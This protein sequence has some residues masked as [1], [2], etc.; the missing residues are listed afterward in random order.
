MQ[1][2]LCGVKVENTPAFNTMKDLGRPLL[3]CSACFSHPTRNDTNMKI[4]IFANPANLGLL[5]GPVDLY[6]DT[7][8]QLCCTTNFYQCLI[9]M[10]YNHSTSSFVPILYALMTHKC[11]ELYAQVFKQIHILSD[12]KM[13][14]RTFTTDFEQGQMNMLSETF[15]QRGDFSRG[16]SL[17]LQA[18]ALQVP[19]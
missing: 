11:K 6:C 12:N 10:I 2:I 4:M 18:G 19:H 8:F 3:H 17:S 5:K 16:I 7:T 9:I 1:N 15:C 14:C 13:Q